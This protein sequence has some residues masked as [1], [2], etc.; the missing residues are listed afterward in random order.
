MKKVSKLLIL[1]ISAYST[2]IDAKTF[3]YFGN[4]LNV[5]GFANYTYKSDEHIVHNDINTAVN[6][7]ASNSYGYISSQISNN[8]YN[9]IR[10]LLLNIP[11][12]TIP[13]NQL[14]F[15]IGRLSIPIGFINTNVSD[16]QLNGSILLPLSTY[17][18]RRYYNLPD[19][20]DG[21][22]FKYT[23]ASTDY[24]LKVNVWYGKQV[25]DNPT[26]DVFGSKFSLQVH[27]DS[28]YGIQLKLDTG[29]YNFKYTYNET[30]GTIT[31]TIPEYMTKYLDKITYQKINFIGIAY[32]YDEFRIQSEST[33]KQVNSTTDELGTYV[34]GSYNFKEK[35]NG[36]IGYS[37]GTRLKETSIINDTFIG[38]SNT[39]GDFSLGL[40]YHQIYTNNWYYGY[41][42]PE[43]H[44]IKTFLTSITYN[45]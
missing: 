18:P 43:H 41:N 37:Y 9:H 4:V 1:L 31:S 44:D 35:W 10:R 38:I 7:T 21:L 20:N 3:E 6:I 26:I 12:I 24:T 14:E 28:T 11:I 27:S 33:F 13:E 23:K 8:E 34:K 30:F 42:D 36:Y 19:I 5:T 39:V 2:T 32:N 16:P 29:D 22:G 17:D 25:I 45:F 15:N 40:E